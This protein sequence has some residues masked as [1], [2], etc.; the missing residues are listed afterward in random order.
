MI[1]KKGA[2]ASSDLEKAEVLNEFF[3]LVFIAGQASHASCVP[4]LLS[5]GLEEQNPS[6]CKSRSIL[7]P[8]HEAECVHIYGAR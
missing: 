2:L 8:H 4:E 1:N 7:R 6:Q 5:G 3:A